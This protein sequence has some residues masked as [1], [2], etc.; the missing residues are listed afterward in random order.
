MGASRARCELLCRGPFRSVFGNIMSK[1]FGHAGPSEGS[2][3]GAAVVGASGSPVE[4]SA[5]STPG[6]TG[7]ASVQSGVQ[8]VDVA[9]LLAGLASKRKEQLDW[10]RSI[11]DMMK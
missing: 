2:A 10:K 7:T 6:T 5:T 8:N 1:V 9:A 3:S 11:V 4:A